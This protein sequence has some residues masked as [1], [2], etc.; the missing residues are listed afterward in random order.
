MCTCGR[1]KEK[2]MIAL[3]SASASAASVA[4]TES[5][6]TNEGEVEQSHLMKGAELKFLYTLDKTDSLKAQLLELVTK[7]GHFI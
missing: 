6:Q 1:Q 3:P 7:K 5:K 2:K 4:E